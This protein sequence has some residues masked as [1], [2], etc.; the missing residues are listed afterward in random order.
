MLHA[1]LNNNFRNLKKNNVQYTNTTVYLQGK[2]IF[3]LNFYIFTNFFFYSV[4][5]G[6]DS[7]RDICKSWG[8]NDINKRKFK[9]LGH[10]IIEAFKIFFI[11]PSEKKKDE[12]FFLLEILLK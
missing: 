2:N 12:Y 6:W 5:K 3:Y 11:S 7:F 1:N 4:L 9:M 8:S 10:G